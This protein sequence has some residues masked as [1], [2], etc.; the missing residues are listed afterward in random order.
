M[1]LE[2]ILAP[3]QLN[4]YFLEN[5]DGQSELIKG[6]IRKF[7]EWYGL[8]DFLRTV[9]DNQNECLWIT[10]TV[11]NEDGDSNFERARIS[12][13]EVIQAVRQG[14]TVCVSQIDRADPRLA[15]LCR[16]TR[17]GLGYVGEVHINAYLSPPGSGFPPH[18]DARSVVNMQIYGNKRWWFKRTPSV[19]WPVGNASFVNDLLRYYD[20]HHIVSEVEPQTT[21]D[22]WKEIVLNPGDVLCMPP[23]VVHTAKAETLSLALNLHFNCVDVSALIGN[24]LGRELSELAHWRF[25]PPLLAEQHL[26]EGLSG[27]AIPHIRRILQDAMSTFNRWAENLE[28]FQEL[29]A[30]A[31]MENDGAQR[32]RPAPISTKS[33]TAVRLSADVSVIRAENECSLVLLVDGQRIT[34]ESVYALV[35]IE[36]LSGHRVTFENLER[37][38]GDAELGRNVIEQLVAIRILELCS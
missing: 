2:Y 12:P 38:C 33:K 20:V 11:T 35:I 25:L 22:P 5:W 13:S 7:K 18:F 31:G 6:D 16:R 36:C 19:P 8:R 32:S 23:G 27:L 3:K 37:V 30:A 1:N 29:L 10:K 21:N 34:C 17:S 15:D 26:Y 24:I 4:D 9:L 14:A 28:E